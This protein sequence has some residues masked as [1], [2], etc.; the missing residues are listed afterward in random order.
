MVSLYL[1]LSLSLSL[2]VF[3]LFVFFFFFSFLP[4]FFLFLEPEFYRCRSVVPVTGILLRSATWADGHAHFLVWRTFCRSSRTF[5][6][7]LNRLVDGFTFA[8]T[9]VH[10]T[11]CYTDE[12]D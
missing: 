5:F 10:N 1:S 6:S 12:N 11:G 2:F 7:D 8:R 4:S 3:F 9:A